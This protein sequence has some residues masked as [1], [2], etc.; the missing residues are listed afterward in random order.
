[1]KHGQWRVFEHRLEY[2]NLVRHTIE[3]RMY[4]A[5]WVKGWHNSHW[6]QLAEERYQRRMQ[7]RQGATYTGD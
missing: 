5:D 7:R 3:A 2:G 6:I 1:M 4:T